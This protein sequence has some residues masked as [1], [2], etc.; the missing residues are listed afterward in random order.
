MY[1]GE[2]QS[3]PSP[4]QTA[5]RTGE[6]TEE[7]RLINVEEQIEFTTMALPTGLV[8]FISDNQMEAIK[9]CPYWSDKQAKDWA[10]IV[11]YIKK[12]EIETG[13]FYGDDEER[14]QSLRETL[15]LLKDRLKSSK[16]EELKALLEEI[17]ELQRL[18]DEP[19]DPLPVFLLEAYLV[20]YEAWVAATAVNQPF[21][22]E[23]HVG[24]SSGGNNGHG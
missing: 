13:R 21:L 15:D 11:A 19:D 12:Q 18:I 24:R 6:K 8:N 3:P 22:L 2:Y 5:S 9:A 17:K 16:A 14:K 7:R 4:P 20:A 1:P 23:Q 10:G